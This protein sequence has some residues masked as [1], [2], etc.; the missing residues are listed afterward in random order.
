MQLKKKLK[1][2]PY[3]FSSASS[4][5]LVVFFEKDILKEVTTKQGSLFQLEVIKKNKIGVASANQFDEDALIS[6]ALRSSGFGDKVSYS[7][8]KPQ[9]QSK[10]KLYSKKVSGIKS[11]ELIKLG[12]QIIRSIKKENPNILVDVFL[13]KS[14]ALSHLEHSQRFSDDHKETVL[15]IAAGGELVSKGDILSIEGDFSWRDLTFSKEKFICD[16]NKKFKLAKNVVK[17]PSTKLPIIFTPDAFAVLLGPVETALS[18]K[19]VYKKVSK[20]SDQIGKRIADQCF[21]L[22]DDPT[23]DFATGS[24]NS[25]DEGLIAK[26]FLLIEK[27]ILKNFYSD[28]KYAEKLN[29][30]PN[31]RGFGIPANPSLT[32]V[33]VNCGTKSSDD[34]IH[35]LKRGM[36][37]DQLL[38]AGQDS[39]YSGD[40]SVNIHLGFLIEN[41][42]IVGRVKN[43]MVSGNIFEMLK[44][45]LTDLSSNYKWVGGSEKL[46]YATFTDINI[47]SNN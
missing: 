1:S 38:G 30:T 13:A 41:G 39:P 25:D 3:R 46:P 45:N 33:I 37:V 31:G 19:S 9:Q 32:N 47:T 12:R 2:L 26:P 7:Y 23:I 28:L 5:R 4:D 6:R 21:T 8:P 24:A 44:N 11:D 34:I 29:I 36:L 17:V 16:I 20:W 42:K 10:I 22:I 35:G 43:C 14:E 40:F 18:A 27:G 15:T